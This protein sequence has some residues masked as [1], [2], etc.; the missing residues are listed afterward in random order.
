MTVTVSGVPQA[1]AALAGVAAELAHPAAAHAA[2]AQLIAAAARPPV[3]TGTLAR[4]VRPFPGEGARVGSDIPYSALVEAR[5]HFLA[6]AVESTRPQWLPLYSR[7][8]AD[9]C[10]AG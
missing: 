3:Q 4:S 7:A 10:G 2:A 8:V 1:R 6:Q 9:I 5:T